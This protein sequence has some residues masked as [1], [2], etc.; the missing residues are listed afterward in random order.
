[1]RNYIGDEVEVI[2]VSEI[3]PGSKE[4]WNSEVDD[5]NSISKQCLQILIPRDKTELYKTEY[6][7]LNYVQINFKE[8]VKTDLVSS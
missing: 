3:S 2:V 7:S 8:Y 6:M 5:E 1:M 4:K